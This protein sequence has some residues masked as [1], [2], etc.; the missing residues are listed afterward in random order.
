[1][2]IFWSILLVTL[3]ALRQSIYQQ[4]SPSGRRVDNAKDQPQDKPI[5][6]TLSDKLLSVYSL[7][8][9]APGLSW[10]MLNRFLFWSAA[11]A[12]RTFI[13]NYM[14]DVLALPPAEAQVL[15]SRI[16]LL[17]GIGVFFLALPAGAVADRIGRQPLLVIAGL[18][19]AGGAVLLII[20]RD[21]NLLF[22]AGGLIAVGAGIFAS[23]SWALAT[24][25]APKT[26]GALYLGLA[27]GATVVGSMGGRMG[28]PLIDGV[29]QFTGTVTIGY[30]V[31]FG[32]ATLFFV[33]SSAVVLKI[34]TRHIDAI[35]SDNKESLRQHN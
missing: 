15:S 10:W 1:M 34:P 17:L 31:V 21:Q 23:S 22:I 9:A 3:Y 25:L 14:E 33:G 4:A 19:A 7:I 27:N 11:I 8:R 28:G 24:D 12:I 20:L 2:A 35:L 32:I 13:L 26:Q 29:N 18:M 5:I 6:K 30:L 16:F